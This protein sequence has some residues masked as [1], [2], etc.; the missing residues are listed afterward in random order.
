MSNKQT[1]SIQNVTQT[2]AYEALYGPQ[3]LLEQKMRKHHEAQIL[4]R[5]R[6]LPI[7]VNAQEPTAC[8]HFTDACKRDGFISKQQ[9]ISELINAGD[10]LEQY[11]EKTYYHG[12]YN[13]EA[14]R[15][16]EENML[17]YPQSKHDYSFDDLYEDE[18]FLHD[19]FSGVRRRAALK[20]DELNDVNNEKSSAPPPP[21]AA[22]TG[23]DST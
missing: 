23:A 22:T 4:N 19:Y 18:Q 17:V 10:R 12:N 14:V 8:G 15:R 3:K 21:K 5:K 2:M 16:E 1:E 13:P 9:M 6:G 20:R 7:A 11:R